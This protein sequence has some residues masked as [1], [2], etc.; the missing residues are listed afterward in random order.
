MS[1]FSIS[2]LTACILIFWCTS[3]FA[4]ISVDIDK[5]VN[6]RLGQRDFGP[7]NLTNDLTSC[8]LAF[9]RSQWTDSTAKLSTQLE[10]SVDGGPFEFWLGM[11]SEGGP[12]GLETSM[13]RRLP[14]GTNRKVQGHYV[15]SGARFRSTVT[16]RCS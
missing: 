8:T 6:L 11:T 7:L 9:D 4:A 2:S 12:E 16:A 5:D 14:S 13:T 10:I 15:V 3:L 1:R